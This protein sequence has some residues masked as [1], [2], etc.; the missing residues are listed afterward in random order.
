MAE[1]FRGVSVE[2][3]IRVMGL[4]P[5]TY[6]DLFRYIRSELWEAVPKSIVGDLTEE[7]FNTIFVM[8]YNHGRA[9]RD[10]EKEAEANE[11]GGS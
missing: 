8:A 4:M 2:L 7:Q 10:L 11:R 1:D 3:A 9:M 5:H 6:T